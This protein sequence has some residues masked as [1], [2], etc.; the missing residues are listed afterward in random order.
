MRDVQ[1]HLLYVIT[2]NEDLV[3]ALDK[4]VGATPMIVLTTRR[5]LQR[6]FM[7]STILVKREM[8]FPPDLEILSK[9][10]H[11]IIRDCFGESEQR[12]KRILCMLDYDL[13]GFLFFDENDIGLLRLKEEVEENVDT[14]LLE[15]ALDLALEIAAEGREGHPVGALFVLGDSESVLK[16]CTE[17]I[18]NPF[19]G[20]PSERRNLHE[21]KNWE[22]IK[23]FAQ[24]DGAC[25]V[26]DNGIALTA[27]SYINVEWSILLEGGFGGRHNA[28]ATISKK[29]DAI[30]VVVSE[31][32]NIR[33]FKDG[34]PIFHMKGR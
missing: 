34:K 31:T 33:I 25:I 30:A 22:T 26:D 10:R 12:G 18:I 6:H 8:F 16:H 19:E 7:D 27:G 1:P 3:K 21:K 23:Q 14:D 11:Y 13:S 32:G 29:T 15:H 9:L 2:D 20:H 4:V 24:L 28:A 5:N 17:Q